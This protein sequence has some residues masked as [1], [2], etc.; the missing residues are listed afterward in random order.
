MDIDL[1]KY[2][3]MIHLALGGGICFFTMYV[4]VSVSTMGLRLILHYFN[5]L[6]LLAF[7]ESMNATSLFILGTAYIPSGFFGGLYTGYKIKE[8]L[9]I[10]FLF[11]ALIGSAG[12]V[13]LRF[14]SGY[15][16]FSIL[17]LQ[18]EFLIPILGN[19]VG[20]YLGGYA[21]NWEIEEIEKTTGTIEFD[22]SQVEP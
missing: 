1:S 12:L 15:T 22:M 19:V 4:L 17:N 13:I 10:T 7:T 16:S 9:R 21:M 20:S 11:P 6:G 14:L 18:Q 2:S 8:N 3:G 5:S